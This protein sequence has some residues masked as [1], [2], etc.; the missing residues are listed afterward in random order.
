MSIPNDDW[1]ETR[2]AYGNDL[3]RAGFA[4]EF[5]RRNADYA[6][7]LVRLGAVSRETGGVVAHILPAGFGA[8]PWGLS[9][10]RTGSAERG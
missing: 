6:S 1:R 2:Q 3:D 4:W 5:V 10:R 9:F 7:H 8:E